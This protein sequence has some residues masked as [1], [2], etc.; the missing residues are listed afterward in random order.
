[1]SDFGNTNDDS[2]LFHELDLLVRD[3]V[4]G[5]V[6]FLKDIG[7]SL[8]HYSVNYLLF[9]Q[10]VTDSELTVM[11]RKNSGRITSA[12]PFFVKNS[13]KGKVVNSGAYFGSHGGAIGFDRASCI[14]LLKHI[15]AIHQKSNYI[16]STIISNPFSTLELDHDLI[17]FEKVEERLMQVSP[18]PSWS[19]T[20]LE[21]MFDQVHP[22][23]RN[24]IRKSLSAEVEVR[25]GLQEVHGLSSLHAETAISMNRNYK[26]SIFFNE[27]SNFFEY[28]R[29][30][31]VLSAYSRDNKILGALL[32]F[33][34]EDFVEYYIPAQNLE[35]RKMQVMT[36]LIIEGF[37]IASEKGLRFWNWGGTRMDQESLRHFKGRWGAKEYMYGFYNK[38]DRNLELHENDLATHFS[39]FYVFK[40]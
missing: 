14:D 9:I 17:G 12:M 26:R 36:R 29:D 31:V 30:Y 8:I 25:D 38:H 37:R 7:N 10:T 13:P 11:V 20:F 19:D 22:K 34:Y 24:L 15:N 39:G 18:I 1:M 27:L 2:T 23:T 4:L 40:I 5:Y 16:S 33:F 3:E 21:D 35:G 6:E 28:E 32:L